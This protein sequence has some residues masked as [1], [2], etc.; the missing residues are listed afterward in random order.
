[1]LKN[2]GIQKIRKIGRYNIMYG[3]FIEQPYARMYDNNT[4][5]YQ[6]YQQP[7]KDDI[8]RER[9]THM[10]DDQIEERMTYYE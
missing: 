9:L 4:N 8:A 7:T 6:P 10:G 1:M 2:Y 3:L 5:T